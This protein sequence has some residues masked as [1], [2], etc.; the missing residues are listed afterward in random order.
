MHLVYLTERIDRE[1]GIQRSLTVRVN[2]LVEKYGHMVT[3][4][5]MERD[6]GVPAYR[7]NE[8]VR[9]VFL[10]DFKN[11]WSLLGRIRKRWVQSLYI[12]RSV[13]PDILI[14]VKFTMHNLFFRLYASRTMLVSEI[15]EPYE[16]YNQID[17][18]TLKFK[19]NAMT[20]NYVF[21]RQDLLITLTTADKERWGFNNIEV[22][23]NPKTL[24]V[25]NSSNLS[26]LQVLA[27]GRLHK[28]KGFDKLI[29]VWKIVNEHHNDWVL[30]ICGAG[31]EYDRLVKKIA[32]YRLEDSIKI[33]NR[34]VSVL[35]EYMNSAIFVLTSQYEAFGN[36]LV[37]AKSCGLP[38]VAFDAP[39]GPKEI[40]VDEE[41]GFLVEMNNIDAMAHKLIDLIRD[42][43]LRLR[44]GTAGIKN[45][46][47]YD[48][49]IILEKY[50]SLLNSY[51]LNE[52]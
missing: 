17:K 46:A 7:L 29:E 28:V 21:K 35:S 50:N 38:V 25:N 51:W 15:R 6:S 32:D 37:E 44:M 1:G 4:I 12:L 8:G 14:S 33:E 30:R 3:I 22:V 13:Q 45:S 11:S 52:K 39:H 41:D 2:I 10:D 23:P 47:K 43:N 5:C 18:P 19:F 36:V 48:V 20:R 24:E 9:V 31:E 40:I 26:S 27:V 42:D 34:F 16:Q 49:D